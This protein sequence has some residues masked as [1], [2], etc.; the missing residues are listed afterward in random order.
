MHCVHGRGF[1]A[2]LARLP[3]A[4]VE[5]GHTRRSFAPATVP[6]PDWRHR[7]ASVVRR[8]RG[9][10]VTTR[11]CLSTGKVL[12]EQ[13]ESPAREREGG[14]WSRGS[15]APVGRSE[16]RSSQKGHYRTIGPNCR[17]VA[18]VGRLL[19]RCP[20]LHGAA[21]RAG[22]T[23]GTRARVPRRDSSQVCGCYSAVW[24]G[25]VRFGCL[26]RAAGNLAAHERRRLAARRSLEPAAQRPESSSGRTAHETTC[27]LR[28]LF[29]TRPVG[30]NA[31]SLT[32]HT[33]IHWTIPG[34]LLEL[35]LERFPVGLLLGPLADVVRGRHSKAS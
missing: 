30:S 16:P 25:L 1:H 34:R 9:R 32:P 5:R 24:L 2:L 19:K 27:S 17:L 15:L 12:V 18:P 20:R 28:P 8:C 13:P 26:V 23:L 33:G 21:R 3:C 6:T 29:D 14:G 35:L 4:S 10:R 31:R 7:C 22:D 11:C